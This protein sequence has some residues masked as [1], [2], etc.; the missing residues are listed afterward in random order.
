MNHQEM[1]ESLIKSPN[2]KSLNSNSA[3]I[4]I[5]L[6]RNEGQLSNRGA[7]SVKTGTHTGRSPKDR[8]LVDDPSLSDAIEWGAINQPMSPT[9]FDVLFSATIKALASKEIFMVAG[10]A[11]ADNKHAIGVNVIADLAWHNLFARCMFRKP[12]KNFNGKTLTVLVDTHATK[13]NIVLDLAKNLVVI[14]GTSYAGEIKKAVFSFLNFILPERQVFPM[15]CAST[16]GRE[17]DV[18]LLFG[19]SGTGKTTLSADPERLLIGDDEHGWSESGIFNFEGGCYAKTIK[20]S[21]KAEPHIFDALQFGSLLENVPLDEKTRIPDFFDASLTENTRAA[22]SLDMIRDICPDSMGGH[23]KNIF[24][25]TCDAFGVLPPLSRLNE[26]QAM[27]HFLSGYTAKVAGTEQGVNEPSAT[28]SSCF[29]A[30]F[31]PRQSSIYASLL[32]KKLQSHHC[33]V[34]LINT[35]W[36]GGKPGV[37]HR[38][39]IQVTRALLSGVLHGNFDSVPFKKD[40]FFGLEVPTLCP[41]VEKEMLNPMLAWVNPEHYRESARKLSSL[42]EANFQKFA[43]KVAVEVYNAGPKPS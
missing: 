1:I 34:W 26:F 22:Y 18:A 8:Y 12:I 2:C 6:R 25:L 20:L 10:S 40:S 38:F 30:P 19:L 39:P 24:F 9:D 36:R 4:E 7:F 17:G 14:S 27:Y 37:G 33:K 23:P 3:L 41:G 35:G 32:Q 31:M 16:M 28:F 5:A 11:C 43:D 15:H 29:G 42:F 13:T 21:P